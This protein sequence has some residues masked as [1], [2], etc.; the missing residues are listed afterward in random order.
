MSFLQKQ[1]DSEG[2]QEKSNGN[3]RKKEAKKGEVIKKRK[4]RSQA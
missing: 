2:N 1:I 4:E 3:L